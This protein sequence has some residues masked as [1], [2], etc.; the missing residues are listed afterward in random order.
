MVEQSAG[1]R[2]VEGARDVR[3]YIEEMLAEL[4]DLASASGERRLATTLRMTALEAAR[5]P[6][7]V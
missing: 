1:R 6:E 4:A 2:P 3:A 7:R 5:Q